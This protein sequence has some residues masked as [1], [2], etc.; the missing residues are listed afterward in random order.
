L[1][2]ECLHFFATAAFLYGRVS[3]L[4]PAGQIRPAKTF[5]QYYKNNAFTT[6]IL[7]W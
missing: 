2:K 1:T 3:K 6:N 4:P 7:I 5:S